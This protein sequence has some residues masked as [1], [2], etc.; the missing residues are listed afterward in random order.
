MKPCASQ[1]E[2]I[3]GETKNIAYPP[4]AASWQFAS[5]AFATSPADG[6][7][8]LARHTLP[9]A[10]PGAVA[11]SQGGSTM[12]ILVT[13]SSGLVGSQLVP[14]LCSLG[15]NVVRLVRA[16]SP[17][18]EGAALWD[19]AAGTIDPHA[20]RDCDAAVNLAGESI[21]A[22]RWSEKRKQA[23]LDSRVHATRTIA[24]ALASVEPKP[25]V[26]LSAS[27]VGFYGPRGGEVLDETAGTGSGDFL[28]EVCRQWEA[29]TGPAAAA[30]VRVVAARFGVILSRRGGALAKM[31]L[32]FKLGLGGR[33]GSGQQ[34][35]SWIAIDD[36]VGAILHA[37]NA[38]TLSGPVNVVAPQPVTNLEFT[39]TLGRVLSRPTIFPMP[40]VAA[41]AAFGQMGQELLLSGQRVEP[42]ALLASGYTFKFPQLET[43]L[44]HVLHR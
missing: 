12:K 4:A 15:H 36:V 16:H 19:P 11:I 44:R 8:Y 31:L 22:G 34:Y 29:A 24:A 10:E 20:L 32:P 43:A 30:G 40:A 18:A 1:F 21:A 9:R 6:I 28:S 26:L 2:Q 42:A 13:G 17:V 14:A 38:T 39:R 25:R 5:G 41:R 35:M 23:I 7:E 33:V 3:D 37:L 27:A